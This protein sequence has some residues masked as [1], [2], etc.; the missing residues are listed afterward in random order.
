MLTLPA[1]R[2]VEAWLV[3]TSDGKGKKGHEKGRS[4]SNG[5]A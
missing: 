4:V 3:K 2:G 1:D 5:E